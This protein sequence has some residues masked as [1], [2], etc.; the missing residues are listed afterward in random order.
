MNFNA[1]KNIENY[2]NLNNEI[3]SNFREIMEEVINEDKKKEQNK[4]KMKETMKNIDTK[5][6]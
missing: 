2:E 1:L 4:E 5:N 3:F 6:K